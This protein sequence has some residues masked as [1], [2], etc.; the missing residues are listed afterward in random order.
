MIRAAHLFCRRY[1]IAWFLVMLLLSFPSARAATYDVGPNQPL[2]TLSDVPWESLN[3][4]D[5][6]RIHWRTNAYRDKWLISRSGT[7]EQ[8]IVVRG[9][10]GPNGELPVINGDGARTRRVLNFWGENRG[11]IKL[12]GSNFPTNTPTHIVIDGLEIRSGCAPYRFWNARGQ[13]ETYRGDGAA[14]YI[15]GGQDITIRNCVIHDCGNGLFSAPTSANLL[16]EGNHLHGNGGSKGDFFL[17][18]CYMNAAGIIF[19]YNHFGPLRKGSL[20]ANLKDR[21]AGTVIC[22][23][24]I[25]GGG[26]QLSL[27][28]A[29]RVMGSDALRLDPRYRTT[30]VYGN[31]L[32]EPEGD[33]NNMMVAYGGDVGDTA[34]YRKG[35]L[36][37]YHN[38]VVSHRE[39]WT[40]LFHLATDD[41]RADCRNNIILLTA[42]GARLGLVNKSGHLT[43]SHNW[44]NAGYAAAF[45]RNITGSVTDD[46]TNIAGDSPGFIDLAAQ[47]FRLKPGSPCLERSSGLHPD[48]VAHAVIRQYIKH[49]QGGPRVRP[50]TL[51]LGAFQSLSTKSLQGQER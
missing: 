20:G 42:R 30:F 46:G 40:T 15:E 47:D 24:W 3:A 44:L 36:H 39:R 7:A 33:G 51:D 37:F 6:V 8:P 34:T 26:V 27:A 4:G 2:A 18:N 28:E 38:T 11:V 12:G 9:V 50:G 32:I 45:D 29:A 1:A 31:V 22:Y 25:E 21:S 48:A 16:I 41:E 43:L 19:Q 23:N 49:Q 35:T 5:M 13:E 17:H 10:P 14:I